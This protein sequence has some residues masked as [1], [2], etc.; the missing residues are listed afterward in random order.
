MA[1][2]SA[3]RTNVKHLLGNKPNIN[4]FVDQAINDAILQLVLEA[5]PHEMQTSKTFTTTT[6]TEATALESDC[7]AILNV[8]DNTNNRRILPGDYN[9]RDDSDPESYGTPTRWY[10]YA[11][12]LN[13]YQQVP[14]ATGFSITYRYLKRP[15]SLSSDSSVLALNDEWRKPVEVLSAAILFGNLN[16]PDRA[17]AKYSEYR[18]LIDIRN[19]PHMIEVEVPERS[20]DFGYTQGEDF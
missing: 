19:T 11:N 4:T 3:L 14:D 13:L 20:F 2:L 17:A 18:T 1:T 7:Y 9:Y 12:N 5:R 16:E 8:T 15:A 6:Q 10:R